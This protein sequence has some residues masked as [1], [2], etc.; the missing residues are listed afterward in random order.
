MYLFNVI[1][2]ATRSIAQYRYIGPHDFHFIHIAGMPV[3]PFFN[4]ENPI[5]RRKLQQKNFYHI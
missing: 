3:W 1:N 2:T 4:S 5:S